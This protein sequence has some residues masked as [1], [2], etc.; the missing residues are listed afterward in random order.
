MNTPTIILL[1]FFGSGF[2]GLIGFAI[3]LS[4]KEKS[5]RKAFLA[6]YPEHVK[7]KIFKYSVGTVCNI[8]ILS[9]ND[10]H[11]YVLDKRTNTILLPV[12]KNK[13][14]ACFEPESENKYLIYYAL[15]LIGGFIGTI[16][17]ISKFLR[18][19]TKP[20]RTMGDIN[21]NLETVRGGFYELK[22]NVDNK[23]FKIVCFEGE[24][25]RI[26]NFG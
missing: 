20:M 13:I 4:V 9:V 14:I 6:K 7:M 1:S 15:S 23:N 2:L 25:H 5:K 3:Y 21:I 22:A 11:E 8:K 17:I 24:N 10:Q 16:L 12:G 19:S 26:E 18:D